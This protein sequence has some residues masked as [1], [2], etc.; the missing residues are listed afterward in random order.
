ME[1]SISSTVS[2]C[3]LR[4][5]SSL[6]RLAVRAR[7]ARSSEAPKLPWWCA[8]SFAD[9]RRCLDERAEA[10]EGLGECDLQRAA[11][12]EAVSCGGRDQGHQQPG[13]DE[14]RPEQGGRRNR[15]GAGGSV[16]VRDRVDRMRSWS[17]RASP[18]G[19]RYRRCARSASRGR[20]APRPNARCAGRTGTP[21]SPSR[22]TARGWPRG[23]RSPSGPGAA[24]PARA[25][26]RR[27]QRRRRR[28]RHAGRTGAGGEEVTVSQ[29]WAWALRRSASVGSARRSS[30]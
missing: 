15:P 5:A 4:M 25:P 18:G 2:S 28:G 11:G 6:S 9:A 3:A 20:R 16:R 13:V 8:S 12:R 23:H 29:A 19:L 17:R 30:V 24:R 7:S 26:G 10:V 21:A 22:R 27:G 1:D 14:G